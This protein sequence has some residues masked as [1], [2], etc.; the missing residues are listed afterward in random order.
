MKIS[1]ITYC[2]NDTAYVHELLR[3]MLR[4]TVPVDEVLVIDDGS[5]PPFALPLNADG[6]ISASGASLPVRVH[7]NP[8]NLGPA[9]TKRVGLGMA[10]GDVLVSLD[11]DIRVHRNF[12]RHALPCLAQGNVGAVGATDIRY[13]GPPTLAGRWHNLRQQARERRDDCPTDFLKGGVFVI[14]Q[15]VYRRIGGIDASSCDVAEDVKMSRDI[16]KLGLTL[17][18]INTYRTYQARPLSPV[19]ACRQNIVYMGYSRLGL[20]AEQGAGHC[21]RTLAHNLMRDL[22]LVR[23]DDVTHAPLLI[24][25]LLSTLSMLTFVTHKL[26]DFPALDATPLRG[27]LLHL[28]SIMGWH[29]PLAALAHDTLRILR[30]PPSPGCSH[31][32]GDDGTQ[33]QTPAGSQFG[34]DD[35]MRIDIAC[36]ACAAAMTAEQNPL[37]ILE[38]VAKTLGGTITQNASS[39]HYLDDKDYAYGD[40]IGFERLR[41]K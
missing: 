16:R 33:R 41:Q 8:Q 36:G 40:Y 13:S 22:A 10:T 4:W 9:L 7:R 32:V 20:A 15:D 23:P 29:A 14:R 21:A 35:A 19:Q 1:I 34:T 6:C 38:G 39:F 18:E 17:V 37:T 25:P 30:L 2:Y 24:M 5:D 3:S 31:P 11:C 12:V 28:A 26:E 27:T